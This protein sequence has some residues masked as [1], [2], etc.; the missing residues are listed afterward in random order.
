MPERDFISVLGAGSIYPDLLI[1]STTLYPLE[2]TMK[3][4]LSHCMIILLTLAVVGTIYPQSTQGSSNPPQL[5]Q[6]EQV[7]AV[8][9]PD[10]H[11]MPYR[12]EGQRHTMQTYTITPQ[13]NDSNCDFLAVANGI[14]NIG[15]DGAHA[16]W[17]AR[18]LVPQQPRDFRE[19]YYTLLGAQGSD[20][21]FSL[22]NLGAAPAAFVGVYEALGYNAVMLGT[23]P[24]VVDA[25]FA[26]AIYE[27]LAA[28]PMQSFA[29]L[30][31]TP[32]PYN[33]QARVLHV[34][35]TGEQAELLYPYHEV[36]AMVS[37]DQP[38]RVVILD[39]LVGYAY[40]LS[41]DE[42]AHYLRGFNQVI[43]VSTTI[44]GLPE[45]Q[46]IQRT[47]QGQPYVVPTLGSVFLTTARQ[48]W[49]PAYGQWGEVIGQPFRANA[50]DNPTVVLPGRYVWYERTGTGNPTF[51]PLG[52]WMWQE[53][54][55]AGI[56]QS[57]WPEAGQE[58]PLVNGIRDWVVNQF[59]TEA[60]FTH[61]FGRVLSPEFWV[62]HEQMQSIILRG[63][64]FAPVD[65]HP[66]QGYICVVTERAVLAWDAQQGV[67]M[68]PLGQVYYE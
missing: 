18:A 68:V 30:W 65:T 23:T 57:A 19:S 56:I 38:D 39:G 9:G 37:P 51:V 17:M 44:G 31:I 58:P 55:Q 12:P 4:P 6:P 42:L 59:G 33:P 48:T 32:R 47:V 34:A 54:H 22:D 26:R 67:L 21:R 7:I 25:A 2:D 3:L 50:G 53:L 14:Q 36:A 10:F 62:S 45:H 28:Q 11:P 52:A 15:G 5:A 27:R 63:L 24:H 43:I 40:T 46:H 16:Y 41:L 66:G 1:D 8:Y 49:G 13:G 29:H 60:Q 64:P 20:Q 35:E 61:A